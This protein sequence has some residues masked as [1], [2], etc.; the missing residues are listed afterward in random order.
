MLE[1]IWFS[2]SPR[3]RKIV[4]WTVVLLA[5]YTVI[6]FLILPPV[7]RSVAAKQLTKQLDRE[8]SI[9]QDADRR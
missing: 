7:I 9:R 1:F 5:A 4:V 6:G 8:V 3:K 2:L